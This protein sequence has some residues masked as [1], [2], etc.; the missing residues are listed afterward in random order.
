MINGLMSN[1]FIGSLVSSIF[2]LMLIGLR[3]IL[4]KYASAQW[5]YNLWFIVLI[6]WL[7]I[8]LP[9]NYSNSKYTVVRELHAIS[10]PLTLTLSKIAQSTNVTEWAFLL[11][12]ITGA[13]ITFSYFLCLHLRSSSMIKRNARLLTAK[14]QMLVRDMVVNKNISIIRISN[15]IVSPMLCHLVRPKIYL[16][17]NYFKNFK[18]HEQKYMLLHEFSHYERCDLFANAAFLIMSCLNWFNPV[19]WNTYKHFRNAQE[20]SCDA[21]VSKSFS[22]D[23]KKSYGYA[24][25]KIVEQH[26]TQVSVMSCSWGAG[27]QLKERFTLLK[28]HNERKGKS[29]LGMAIFI[30]GSCVAIAAPAM[31]KYDYRYSGAGMRLQAD[32]IRSISSGSAS[33][34]EGH[35]RVDLNNGMKISGDKVMAQYKS[36]NQHKIESFTIYG[37][38]SLEDGGHSVEFIN[39]TYDVMRSQLMAEQIIERK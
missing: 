8:C 35:V 39:G 4:I 9:I 3:K 14:E 30:M 34:L 6:P 10:R 27:N 19:M 21:V 13:A 37:K 36:D 7:A 16:P 2:V 11:F 5:Y 1:V 38:G 26:S 20:V 18:A 32:M 25:L 23:E 29:L 22:A 24:L 31:G 33:I 17:A 28:F 15:V 12:W